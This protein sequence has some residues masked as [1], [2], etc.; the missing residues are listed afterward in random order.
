MS[1]NC[2]LRKLCRCRVLAKCS[3][4]A[5]MFVLEDD[6]NLSRR[7][8]ATNSSGAHHI[9]L[10]SCGNHLEICLEIFA[11]DGCPVPLIS[12]LPVFTISGARQCPC[13]A[14][15]DQ[16]ATSSS[17]EEGQVFDVTPEMGCSTGLPLRLFSTVPGQFPRHSLAFLPMLLVALLCLGS[18]HAWVQQVENFV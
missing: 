18:A 12:L 6:A 2:L 9:L 17:S 1:E 16:A 14:A 5:G 4:V 15:W 11:L 7:A 13:L 10:P 8:A 3:V